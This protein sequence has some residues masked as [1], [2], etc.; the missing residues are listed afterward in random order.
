MKNYNILNVK[1][2]SRTELHDALFLTGAEISINNLEKGSNVPFVH[3]HKNNEEIYL[4]YN[5]KGYVVIDNERIELSKGDCIRISPDARRQFFA[6]KD[7]GISYVC[8]QVKSNSLDGYTIT[9]AI[10]E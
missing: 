4:I 5:G 7:E 2:N 3:Y 9:D 8:I 10:I 1:L 6:S